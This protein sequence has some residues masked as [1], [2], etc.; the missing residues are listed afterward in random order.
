M[1]GLIGGTANSIEPGKRMLSSMTPT[2]ISKDGKLFAVVGTPGGSTI[3]TANFQ[4]IVD[5]I[6]YKMPM[7][8]AVLSPKCTVNGFRM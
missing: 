2:I 6:D 4:T 5:V 1:F 8:Q 3:I 7:L